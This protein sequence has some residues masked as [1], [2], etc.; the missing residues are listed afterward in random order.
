M[1]VYHVHTHTNETDTDRSYDNFFDLDTEDEETEAI[2]NEVVRLRLL[3]S[4]NIN[5]ASIAQSLERLASSS[6]R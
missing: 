4:I 2:G 1:P 5:L 6:G 3:E